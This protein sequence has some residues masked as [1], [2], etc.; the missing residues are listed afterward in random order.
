MKKLQVRKFASISLDE[1]QK[2]KK[3]QKRPASPQSKQPVLVPNPVS[4]LGT[5]RIYPKVV[6]MPV[7]MP[8]PK[9]IKV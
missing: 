2:N 8:V 6:P 3:P 4:Q 7:G 9:K 5:G 1:S